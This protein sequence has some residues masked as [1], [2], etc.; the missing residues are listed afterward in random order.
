LAIGWHCISGT[1]RAA[2]NRQARCRYKYVLHTMAICNQSGSRGTLIVIEL[3]ETEKSY[4]K[5]E[6][7]SSVLQIAQTKARS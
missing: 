5:R 3:S 4:I 2:V 6:K 1:G 7:I